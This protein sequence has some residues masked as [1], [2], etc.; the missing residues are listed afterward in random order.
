MKLPRKDKYGMPYVSYSQISTFRRSEEDYYDQYILGTP[1]VGN[2]YTDFGSK[3]GEALE[4]CD[5]SKFNDGEKEILKS[6]TRLDIFERKTILN[7]DGFYVL[8]FI[9]TCSNDFSKL[10][11]YK[12]GGKGKSGKYR[13]DDY[14]QLHLYALSIRQETGVTP[15]EA[16]VQFITRGGKI[17]DPDGFFVSNE[18]VKSIEIDIS[19]GRLKEVYWDTMETVKSMSE[20]YKKH[21]TDIS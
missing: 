12:T 14:D 8:G 1:F 9:D 3:V 10:I 17:D 11:D 13:K 20:F 7:Y 21:G 16:L 19:I 5:Y 15:K 18:S 4:G 6:V 2:A